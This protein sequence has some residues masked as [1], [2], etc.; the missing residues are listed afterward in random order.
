MGKNTREMWSDVL[1]LFLCGN[2]VK[3]VNCSFNNISLK[4]EEPRITGGQKINNV[5]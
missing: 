5:Q 1:T 2:H 3:Q 4:Y